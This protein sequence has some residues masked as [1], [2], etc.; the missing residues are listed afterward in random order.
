MGRYGIGVA[1][2]GERLFEGGETFSISSLCYLWFLLFIVPFIS[3]MVTLL[4]FKAFG[5]LV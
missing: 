2:E 1:L 5:T 4:L 3:W